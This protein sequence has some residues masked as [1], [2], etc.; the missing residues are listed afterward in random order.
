MEPAT[1]ITATAA[2]PEQGPAETPARLTLRGIFRPNKWRILATYGL[3][4]LE[5]LLRL[6][7]PLVVGWAINDLLASSYRGLIWFLAQ[8]LAHLAIGTV[9]QMYDTR[10]FTAI[11]T[12]LA[13]ELVADQRAQ[14]IAVSRVAARSAMSRN[15]V[16]FFEQ[17]VPMVIR[18]LY[19]VVVRSSCWRY[20]M[21]GW[22]CF[23]SV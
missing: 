10:A 15:Y 12:D 21:P 14:G 23:A 18:A 13:A 11:Y 6:A 2:S 8:H 3:F 1:L 17:Y 7:Q 22:L 20:S 9:R 4:S 16:E 19:S 5:N